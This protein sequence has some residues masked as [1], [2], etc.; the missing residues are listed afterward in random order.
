MSTVSAVPIGGAPER[1]PDTVYPF[2]VPPAQFFGAGAVEQLAGEAARLGLTRVLVV[3]DPGVA[4]T[5][6]A[7][8]VR[9]L[10]EAAGIDA[11][12]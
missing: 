4:K 12:L 3:T 8:R 7:D 6:I 2:R 11:S 10:L 5:G 1:R 9:A